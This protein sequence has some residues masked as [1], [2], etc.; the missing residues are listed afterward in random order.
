MNTRTDLIDFA[1][2]ME[3]KK[4]SVLPSNKKKHATCSTLF[5]YIDILSMVCCCIASGKTGI[6]TDCQ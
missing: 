5:Q 4:K 3:C 6:L 1:A 2:I